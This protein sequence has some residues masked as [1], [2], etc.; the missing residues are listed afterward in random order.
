MYNEWTN[1]W[2]GGLWMI[3]INDSALDYKNTIARLEV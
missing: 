3:L 1:G 2:Q